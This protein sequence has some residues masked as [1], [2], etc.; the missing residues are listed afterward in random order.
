MQPK[1][2]CPRC[3][4]NQFHVKDQFGEYLS[5]LQCGRSVDVE[6]A[7]ALRMSVAAAND[8]EVAASPERLE[9]FPGYRFQEKPGA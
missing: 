6:S 1:S 2:R 9:R 7:R 3:G 4:G 8:R 5:C